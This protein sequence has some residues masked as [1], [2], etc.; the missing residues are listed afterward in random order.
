MPRTFAIGD[1]HGCYTALQT[2]VE[3]V[4]IG[5]EDLLVTLGDYVDRGPNS[6]DVLQWLIAR[7]RTGKLIALRGN[8]EVIML[9]AREGR[10]QLQYWRK[11]GGRE[12]LISYATVASEG[13]LADVPAE[14]WSFLERT[15]RYFETP[16]HFFVHANVLADWPLAE[17]PDEILFWEQ[18]R[19]QPPHCSGKIMI[20]GHTPQRSFRPLDLGHSVCID[21]A[22]WKG[23][24]L[25][26]LEPATGRYWQ[27]NQKRET[28][29]GW[30]GD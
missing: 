3:F 15:Q 22:A 13:G 17:Q 23:G 10:D 14:H 8:H 16:T 6:F 9:D 27:A 20:C 30:L 11:V 19:D 4:A 24:W 21:T 2:L 18:L 25:T 29:Q 12:A 28:R 7:D 26:C 1:I 5:D